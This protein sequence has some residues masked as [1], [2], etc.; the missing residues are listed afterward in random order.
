M[1]Q[2]AASDFVRR[3]EDFWRAPSPER[4]NTVLDPAVRLS[5]P[6]TPTTHGLAAGQLSF[7]QLFTLIP[8]MTTSVHRWGATT[9]GVIIEFTA[10][11]TVAGSPV[12]WPSIDRFVINSDGLAT[13]RFTYFDPLPLL[14]KLIRTPRAWPLFARNRF[15]MGRTRPPR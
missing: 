4:L 2:S 13:E 11:G 3:F 5:A 7:E 12:A 1:D 6:M 9:D 14:L 15:S 10:H 8:D